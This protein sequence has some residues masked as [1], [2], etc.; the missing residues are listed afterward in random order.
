MQT[1]ALQPEVVDFLS[2]VFSMLLPHCRFA[3][4]ERGLVYVNFG[5]VNINES[6]LL[7]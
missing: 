1:S 3:G 6:R 4:L 5:A 2:A 7:V